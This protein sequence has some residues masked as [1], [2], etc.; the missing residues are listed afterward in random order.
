M[1]V[2][3]MSHRL[4]LQEMNRHVVLSRQQEASLAGAPDA[5]TSEV[6]ETLVCANLSF[7]VRVAAQHRHL[8]LPF[9]ELVSEGCLGLLQAARRFDARRGARFITY[10]V[11]WIRKAILR[12]AAQNSALVRPSAY[13]NKKRKEF[14]AEEKALAAEL[15]R[16]PDTDELSTRL[17]QPRRKIDASLRERVTLI[18]LDERSAGNGGPALA[19]TLADPKLESAED[20]LLRGEATDLVRQAL[21]RL[22][23]QERRVLGARFGLTGGDP[24][25]LREIGEQMRLSRERVRQIEK[26]GRRKIREFLRRHARPRAQTRPAPNGRPAAAGQS[27]ATTAPTEFRSRGAVPRHPYAMEV[28]S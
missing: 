17:G 21:L 5:R 13:Q 2:S 14:A 27:A 16:R 15:G 6:I 10:A 26:H 7:V 23:D 12:T 24:L 3:R 28:T 20:R 9:E 19:E 11:W 1:E 25:T 8:G 18:S 4:Y 22:S